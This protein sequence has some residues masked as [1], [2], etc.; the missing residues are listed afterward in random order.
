MPTYRTTKQ[1]AALRAQVA[2]LLLEN[3]PAKTVAIELGISE[4]YVFA[5]GRAAGVSRMAV[6]QAERAQI[7]QHRAEALRKGK[8]AA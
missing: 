3:L 2:A 6:T 5:L 8:H 4:G 7:E 1:G